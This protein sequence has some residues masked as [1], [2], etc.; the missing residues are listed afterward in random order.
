MECIKQI[1]A[2][3]LSKT[4]STFIPKYKH[5]SCNGQKTTFLAWAS[6]WHFYMHTVMQIHTN[7][8]GNPP[9]PKNLEVKKKTN[10]H[11]LAPYQHKKRGENVRNDNFGILSLLFYLPYTCVIDIVPTEWLCSFSLDLLVSASPPRSIKVG[12]LRLGRFKLSLLNIRM[13]VGMSGRSSA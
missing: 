1:V 2:I 5:T 11:K 8:S 9:F 13:T 10:L 3:R 6:K 7:R 4:T 12:G